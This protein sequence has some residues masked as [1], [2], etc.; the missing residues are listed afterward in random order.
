MDGKDRPH[1]VS[2][3]LDLGHGVGGEGLDGEFLPV[4]GVE[5][6]SVVGEGV[7]GEPVDVVVA[8]ADPLV[9]FVG[10]GEAGLLVK[11][12]SPIG[13]ESPPVGGDLDGQRADVHAHPVPRSEEVP[14]GRFYG[15]HLGVVPVE[16]QHQ[17]AGE[18]PV[19]SADG[20]PDV[21]DLPGS[22][23]LGQGEGLTRSD[24]PGVPI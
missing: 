4:A 5:V 14:D 18:T 7:E 15:R 11:G 9:R 24:G 3:P 16:P 1:V 22:V 17:R 13:V 19:Q 12:H 23:Q 8:G 6:E 20:E 21:T 10:E 2:L